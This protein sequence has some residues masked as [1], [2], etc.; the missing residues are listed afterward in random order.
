MPKIHPKNDNSEECGGLS[1]YSWAKRKVLA[2]FGKKNSALIFFFLFCI[3]ATTSAKM[4]LRRSG[5]EKP[6]INN[7][8]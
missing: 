4:S 5:L 1:F 6:K 3:S 8:I 7:P 2:T